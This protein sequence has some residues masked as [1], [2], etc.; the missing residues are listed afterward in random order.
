M[1]LLDY[2]FTMDS[3]HPAQVTPLPGFILTILYGHFTESLSKFYLFHGFH[4]FCHVFSF[5]M[6]LTLLHWHQPPL[7]SE[8]FCQHCYSQKLYFLSSLFQSH[9]SPSVATSKLALE[10]PTVLV[11]VNGLHPEILTQ[12]I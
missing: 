4:D 9:I 8:P 2:S 7:G 1:L 5:R 11:V 3:G 12:A 10:L 6:C